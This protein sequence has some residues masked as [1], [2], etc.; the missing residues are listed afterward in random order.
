MKT[1]RRWLPHAL[2]LACALLLPPA[3]ASAEGRGAAF[4]RGLA[5]EP[6]S[7]S[8]SGIPGALGILRHLFAGGELS[9]LDAAD[10]DDSGALDLAD[11]IFVLRFLFQGG[12][13]PPSPH[14]GC[15]PDPTED[16]LGCEEFAPCAP[17]EDGEDVFVAAATAAGLDERPP[18]TTCTALPRPAVGSGVALQQAWP[19]LSIIGVLGLLQA[20]GDSATWY[21]VRKPGYIYRFTDSPSVSTK[22]TVLNLTSRVMS[23]D[24]GGLLSMA[25]HPGFRTNGQVYLFYTGPGTSVPLI[26][27]IS[28]F[29]SPD[30]GATIDIN[31]E[32]R[33]ISVDQPNLMHH[34][35][36]LAFGLDGLL[37]IA[38][39][40]ANI[41]AASQDKQ[42]L[43]GKML[44][45]DV[46]RTTGY[47]IPPTNPFA[48]GGGRPEIYAWGLRQPY[49]WSFDR[50]TGEL[51]LGDVGKA[52]WEEVDLIERGKNYGWPVREGAHCHEPL[53]C[54]STGLT[55]PVVE[56]SHT[57][58][59]CVIGGFVYRG[60]AIPSLAG[61]YIY[62]DWGTGKIWGLFRDGAG[63]PA[64]RVIAEAGMKIWSF[65]QG[66]DGEVYALEGTKTFKLVPA[67][68]A[69]P[70]SFPALLSDTGYV[71]PQDPTQPASCLIPYD[72]NV[73]FWSDGALK[74]RWLAIPD[75]TAIHVGPDGDWEFPV[76][77]VFVKSFRL[78]GKL[79]ETRLFLRH[80]DGGW[81]GYSYE[82][83][84][85]ETDAVLLPGTK[86]KLVGTT[87]WTYPSRD[88]CLLCHTAAAGHSLGPETAQMNRAITY[89]ATGRTANQ[90]ATF[91]AIG[92]LDAP[93]GS[94]PASLPALPRTDD[95]AQPLDL[96]AR[97]YLHS[98]CSHCHRPGGPGRGSADFRHATPDEELGV[99][100]VAPV[101]GDIG[102]PGALVLYPA[103]P[104]RS[105]MS[106][107]MHATDGNRMPPIARNLVDGAGTDLID[108]WILSV[109]SC[110]GGQAQPIVLDNG[111]PGTTAK[112]GWSV[113][114]G[115]NPYGTNSLYANAAG[116]T[117]TFQ[118]GLAQGGEYEVHVWWT[119]W[120]SRLTNVPID[121]IH[122]QGTATIPVNQRAN[123]GKWNKI[124][125]W[126]FGA[127][128][129]VVIRSLGNGT[130]CADA[131]SLIPLGGPP[132]GEE[133][134]VIVDNGGPG[135]SASGYWPPSG[136]TNPY[137][138]DSLYSRTVGGSYT[139]QVPLS[140]PGEYD[141]YLWWTEWPSR[142]AAI[143]VEVTH[144]GGI[145]SSTI[146][147]RTNGGK[148]NL[149]GTWTF[150]TSAT[151]KIK[152]LG[153]GT[154]CAD[155][156][157][158]VRR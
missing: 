158:F 46:N 86:T 99:C 53:N 38:L 120:P 57:E 105:V 33:L 121:V 20:P 14:P 19:S 30:G 155:A 7:E 106:L 95:L 88:E 96:R 3:R 17:G 127:T 83:N 132:A 94:P 91:E 98:N 21:L 133:E 22:T 63:R 146:D 45:I 16:A 149:A 24:N 29:R 131:V 148:W 47:A 157:R 116:A 134:E 78:G 97:A 71:D 32:E 142:N 8:E 138:A 50:V 1:M 44:R 54:S 152:S 110:P 113:S 43:L 124:G 61:I 80:A 100:G 126:S 119:E 76:G 141:V 79:V 114:G 27:H 73:P 48:S 139:Y 10:A 104:S 66:H 64:P 15:G 118:L 70:D 130:V 137:G 4:V 143:P 147:Q 9:C 58:G 84:S 69:E 6:G 67:G 145:A 123:G 153:G 77:S 40:E 154:T 136:G 56:Y 82:W 109:T 81:G 59:N 42:S 51:W 74:E 12:A 93:L 87:P 151:V 89:P 2:F 129:K 28:R 107:R 72:I 31:S 103:D 156:V 68:G 108:D 41:R 36:T 111:Q 37:Y 26:T 52:T 49:R 11:A 92:L 13:P 65:G 35:G 23:T 5:G 18:N 62:A 140:A 101:E 125:S 25:F 128:A 115:A 144:A 150:G 34:G 117:Y 85:T 60:T 75:G 122:S 102:V 112:G 90:L 55:D 39:G 135:T